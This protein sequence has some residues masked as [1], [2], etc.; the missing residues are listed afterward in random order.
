MSIIVHT[1][2][3]KKLQMQ[4]AVGWWWGSLNRPGYASDLKW[5]SSPLR[6]ERV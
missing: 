6:A 5:S 3:Q 1:H 4:T 2:E